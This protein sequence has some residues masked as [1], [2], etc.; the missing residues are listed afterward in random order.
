MTLIFTTLVG[1]NIISSYIYAFMFCHAKSDAYGA[2]FVKYSSQT[3]AYWICIKALY[4]H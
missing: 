2:R 1:I 3:V 4:V